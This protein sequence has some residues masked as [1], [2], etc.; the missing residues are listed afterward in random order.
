MKYEKG[1]VRSLKSMA[2]SACSSFAPTSQLLGIE[3]G[4]VCIM[5][6]ILNGYG[7]QNA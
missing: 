2:S 1:P 5:I 6:D 3:E 4:D 7:V